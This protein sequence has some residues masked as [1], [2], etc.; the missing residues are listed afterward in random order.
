MVVFSQVLSPFLYTLEIL[1]LSQSIGNTSESRD[2][3]KIALSPGES[4]SAQPLRILLGMASGPL[5]FEV[6]R[7]FSSFVTPLV[8]IMMFLSGCCMVL[9]STSGRVSFTCSLVKTDWNCFSRMFAFCRLSLVSVPF[10]LRG[11]TP[12]LS[13]FL[14]LM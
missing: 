12:L 6:L 14:A 7:F 5:A 2:S 10:S 3:W 13:C 1:A 4:C 9:L 11:D 8:S